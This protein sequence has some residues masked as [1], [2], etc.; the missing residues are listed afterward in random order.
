M[1]CTLAG[2]VSL[3]RLLHDLNAPSLMVVTSSG[4][5]MLVKLEQSEKA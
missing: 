4:I 5:V 2:N 1:T 3:L